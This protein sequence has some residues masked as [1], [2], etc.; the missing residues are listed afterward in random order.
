MKKSKHIQGIKGIKLREKLRGIPFEQVLVVSIDPGKFF[1]KALICNFFGE[2]ITQPFFFHIDTNGFKILLDNINAAIK[3]INA[4]KILV[5]IE[6]SGHYHQKVVRFL[7]SKDYDIS[8]INAYTTSEIRSENLNWSKTDD[9][10]LF[11]IADAI[12]K[13]KVTRSSLPEGIYKKLLFL[14]RERRHEVDYQSSIKIKIR[15]Y[16]DHIWPNFQGKSVINNNT[17]KVNKIFSD[18]WGKSSVFIMRNYPHP[19]QVLNLGEK[20]LRKLSKQHCLKMRDS[21]I[22][23]L[24]HAAQTAYTQPPEALNVELTLL[25]KKLNDLEKTQDDIAFLDEKIEELFVKT[26]GVLLLSTPGISITIGAEFTAELGPVDQYNNPS[27]IIKKAGT[28]P[29]VKE[30]GGKKPIYGSISKQ[31]NPKFRYTIYLAGKSLKIH[32]PYFKKFANR[33]KSKGKSGNQINIACGNKFIKVA[34]AMLRKREFFHPP[35]WE[36]K[37][38]TDNPYQKLNGDNNIIEARK[39]LL[40]ELKLD[41]EKF[42]S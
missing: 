13:N 40:R 1:P 34:Y 42:V 32:N 17:H 23:K 37:S 25:N 20:G 3:S 21:T 26:P 15:T 5:G 33:L 39:T 29:I 9:V 10:D 2:I 4:Q 31:G 18:F 30:S 36:G 6:A 7:E 38:L 27:Q 41:V 22:N 12:T 8:I 16:M 24:L 11:A 14:T 35:K 19:T 28:N